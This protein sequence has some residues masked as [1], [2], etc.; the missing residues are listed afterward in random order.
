ML[1]SQ[2]KAKKP[3]KPTNVNVTPKDV[4]NIKFH[5]YLHKCQK[6]WAIKETNELLCASAK[7][8]SKNIPPPQSFLT[9]SQKIT[10]LNLRTKHKA[11]MHF[12]CRLTHFKLAHGQSSKSKQDLDI[13]WKQY[14]E[15]EPLGTE[16]P[17]CQLKDYVPNSTIIVGNF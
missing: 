5:N 11:R 4:C 3:Q 13:L 12:N 17:C 16:C 1:W 10:L 7:V 14:N 15:P 2:N 9:V 8:D 6:Y